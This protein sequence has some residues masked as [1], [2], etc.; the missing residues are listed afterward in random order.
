MGGTQMVAATLESAKECCSAP[1]PRPP[2]PNQRST[3]KFP[4]ATIHHQLCTI[5]KTQP[6]NHTQLSTI[7]YPLL[8]CITTLVGVH[9]LGSYLSTVAS[10]C[11]R[12]VAILAHTSGG[13]F[14][15]AWSGIT[16]GALARHRDTECPGCGSDGNAT[17]KPG[18]VLFPL[19]HRSLA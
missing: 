9:A 13:L 8:A 14:Y 11:L 7:K 4:P 2:T 10:S 6:T 5:N 16:S 1:C 18:V 19:I 17:R 15:V 12:S 3:G